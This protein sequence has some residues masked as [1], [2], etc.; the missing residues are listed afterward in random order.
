YNNTS[1]K[2]H[3]LAIELLQGRMGYP[4]IVFLD[5]KMQ[6]IQTYPGFQTADKFDLLLNYYT[7]DR[8]KKGEELATFATTFKSKIT[9]EAPK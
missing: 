2:A 3:D 1:G 7:Q 9:V 4:S 5:E 6:K 8:H